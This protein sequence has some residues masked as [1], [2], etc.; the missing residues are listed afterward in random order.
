MFHTHSS[1]TDS[2]IEFVFKVYLSYEFDELKGH[3]QPDLIEEALNENCLEGFINKI[4][5]L[6][7][8]TQKFHI[9]FLKTAI[10]LLTGL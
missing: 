6:D 1:V 8:N 4:V 2:D 5:M 9:I 3:Q 7:D 10:L